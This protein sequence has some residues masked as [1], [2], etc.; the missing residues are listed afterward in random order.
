MKVSRRNFVKV[1]GLAS[2]GI[3]LG[4]NFS[5]G[6]IVN[7]LEDGVSF[8][9][10]LFVQLQKDGS[11]TIVVTRSEMGQ[12][13]RTSMASAIADELEAD[14][15]YVTIKQATGDAKFGDQNTD[16]SRSIRTM[17][18]PMRKMGA[19][20]K[21][22]LVSAAAKKWKVA[23]TDCKADDHF[24]MNKLTNEKVFYGD[25]VDAAKDIT[26][27]VEN[28]KL[29]D[30]KDFKYIGKGLR[31]FDIEAFTNGTATYGID[32]RLS[33]MKFAAIARCPATFGTV[34]SFDDKDALDTKGVEKVFALE[35][36]SGA[37]GAL[38]GV[39][40]I[41]SNTW[42]AFQG[43]NNLTIDWDMGPNGSYDTEKFKEKIIGRVQRP[44]KVTPGSEG[45]VKRA[46]KNAEKVID[47]TYFIPHLVHTP[48]EVPNATANVKDGKCEIWAPTQ[49]PQTAKAEVASNLGFDQKNVTINVTFLGGGFGRKSKPDFIVEAA[50]LSQKI[51]APV[52]LVWSRED[53]VQHSYYH[54]MSAQY[55]KGSID[56]EGNV[57]G[58][59]HR[60]AFPSIVSTFKLLSDYASG[61]EL[62]QGF[63][64][65]P[66]EIPNVQLENAK[67]EA[68]VRIGWMRSVC[69]IHHSFA[70][71][72]F[73]DELA[74]AAGRDPLQFKLDL[75]GKDRIREGRSPH[76]F[77]SARLKNVINE[78]KK[79]SDWGKKLPKGHGMGIAF[80][81]SF[82]SYV[83]TVV[84]VSVINN[85][86]KIHNLYSALDCGLYVNKDS[87]LNQ[88]EGAA[89]FGMSIALFGKIT[90]K[91]GAI[92]QNNFF[93]YQMTRMKD[94]PNMEISIIDNDENPT[95]VGEPG[96]PPIAP[97]ICN[98]IYAAS[99]KRI[100]TL[101]LSDHGIV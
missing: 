79:M 75:I 64:N 70:V 7:G 91:D 20:A 93:D 26:I 28:I 52:Q 73:A 85:K 38:G 39:A 41:A 81:Y 44:A 16:G 12:G 90:A 5:E 27:D 58:W 59:L 63:N 29:K 69:N 11:L 67:A 60:T 32:V 84:E 92:E 94:T 37:F 25:L 99:G 46:F 83:A 80:H 45:N 4:C 57:S 53:D 19:M 47:A 24:V 30:K 77:N 17:L 22:M 62:A 65:N 15:K 21:E 61:F 3:L 88:M 9:P 23:S 96:V 35:K 56:K 33:N 74:A 98:A 49:D 48:M 86:L 36:G 40:V 42:A 68:H 50:L 8:V 54:A 31:S 34:K 14:W 87:V 2:G 66:Y 101:P 13:I 89:V 72:S 10:N 78:V 18:D 97:A 82:Y 71:N 43:K 6:V 55:L 95:G 76:S 100:R 1:F 51:K